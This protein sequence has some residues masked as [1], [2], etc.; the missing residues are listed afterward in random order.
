MRRE[1]DKQYLWRKIV[2]VLLIN[3]INIDKVS[4]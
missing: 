3:E 4:V 1:C 2:T